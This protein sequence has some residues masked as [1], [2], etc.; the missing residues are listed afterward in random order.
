LLKEL[1]EMKISTLMKVYRPPSYTAAL[2]IFLY[3]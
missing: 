2:D 3:N 1:E